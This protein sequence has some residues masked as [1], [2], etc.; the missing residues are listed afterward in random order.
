MISGRF[1]VVDDNRLNR[2]MLAQHLGQQGHQVTLA[3]D[4]WQALSLLRGQPFDLMLLDIMMPVMDGYAVLE[5]LHADPALR[6]LPVIVI[7]ALDEMDSVVRCIGMGAADYLTK[8]FDPVLLRA[9]IGACL[10][11]KR[12]RDLELEY[13]VQVGLVVDAAQAVEAADF[14]PASLDGVA[15]REDA[16]GRLARVFQRM[17]QEVYAREQRLRRQLEQLRLDM[18]EMRHARQQRLACYLPA[19]RQRALAQGLTLPDRATGAALSA[20]I[21]GFTP[22]AGELARELGRQRGAEE[23]TRT[24]NQVYTVLINEVHRHGGSVIGFAGDAITCWFDDAAGSDA[25]AKTAVACALAMQTAMTLYDTVTTPAGTA[26]GLA[27][28]AAVAAGPVRRLLVGDPEIQ[29]LEA[30]A[31]QTV[32][33]LAGGRARGRSGRSGRGGRDRRRRQR[34]AGYSG[35]APRRPR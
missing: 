8:P 2:L 24:I 23:L 9:R 6:N 4:G 3:E 17:A 11:N 19:D 31:G 15:M 13:L 25:A 14:D 28:K 20:D 30:I 26:F 10:E 32:D 7:S 29:L 21:S 5:E 27:V 22:L 18:E 34:A 16:L 12:L 33:R 35:V 1:L